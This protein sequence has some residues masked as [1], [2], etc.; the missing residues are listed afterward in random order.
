MNHEEG[1]MS[2]LDII[3]SLEKELGIQIR[4]IS[5]NYD[6]HNSSN[7]VLDENE[8]VTR[9]SIHDANLKVLPV[10]ITKLENLIELHLVRNKLKTLPVSIKKL[11]KLLKLSLFSNQ[12]K[13]FPESITELHNL[14][15]LEIDKNHLNTLPD[16]IEKLQNLRKLNIG[17]NQFKT[18]PN[19]ITKLKDL[20][21]LNLSDNQ[22]KTLPDSISELK[23]LY[24][25]RLDS[26]QLTLFP[27][28]ITEL[29][30]LTQLYY[31]R[32]QLRIIPD[33]IKKLKNL[34]KLWFYNNHLKDIPNSISELQNLRGLSFGLNHITN[35][36]DS[37]SELMNLKELYLYDNELKNIPI[38]IGKLQNLKEFH[39]NNNKLETLPSEIV[40]LKKLEKFYI[41]ENL[42]KDPPIEIAVQGIDAI[43][44]YFEDK[45]AKGTQKLNQVK[46]LLLGAGGAGKTSLLKRIFNEGFNPSEVETD[47]IEIRKWSFPKNG[48]DV[49]VDFWDFGG[50]QIMHTTHQF[51]LSKRSLYIL[52]LDGREDQ[53]AEHW[54]KMIESFGGDSPILV[55][56][57][58]CDQTKGYSLDENELKSKYKG[59]VDF[60]RVSC[61]TN[62]YIDDFKKS[63]EMELAKVPMIEMEWPQN[64]FNAKEQF[65][66]LDDDFITLERFNEICTD[67]EVDSKNRNTVRR[68][69]HELGIIL[70]FDG[71]HFSHTQ[72]LKPVWATEGVYKI[73]NFEKLA[74]NHGIFECAWLE[75]ALKQK[76]KT[77]YYYPS[78][79]WN[80]II[81][82]M[83]KF[84]ICYEIDNDNLLIPDLLE[85]NTPLYVGTYDHSK[86]KIRFRLDYDFFP[87]SIIPRFIVR[88]HLEIKEDEIE[89]SLRWRSGVVLE[90]K[91]FDAEAIIK[92]DYKEKWIQIFVTGRQ[93]REYFAVILTTFREIHSS[94]KKFEVNE[95]VCMKDNMSLTYPYENLIYDE[96]DGRINFR[97]NRTRKNYTVKEALGSL[98]PVFKTEKEAQ[99]FVEKLNEQSRKPENIFIQIIKAGRQYSIDFGAKVASNMAKDAAMG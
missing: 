29:R 46:V 22:L 28:S 47:G 62:E 55:V 99:E 95:N 69:L 61:D 92:A 41:G 51:F 98:R 54:L 67:S 73:I 6:N 31:S 70:H 59:I 5:P 75:E 80:Y 76:K 78:E 90:N 52:V 17:Y 27:D 84:E 71:R 37:I 38:E 85:E 42:L 97:P 53:D 77:E 25:I 64:W 35:L 11:Q 8:D 26:N 13:I 88:R 15:E 45:K 21:Q 89:G 20:R 19:S 14:R 3:K 16:S 36:P 91:E 96:E 79:R 44:K 81:D 43:R 49:R 40:K 56:K 87:K 83:K 58:K 34:K 10:S 86:D 65:E 18:L 68:T 1:K 74:E 60:Y 72:V 7:Y 82:L 33:S 57:N 94:F 23:N 12:I 48:N 24:K 4:R 30:K 2:D 50:Q 32:N 39:I 93:S 66:N 9:L 63:L